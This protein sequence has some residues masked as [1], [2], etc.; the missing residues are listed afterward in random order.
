MQDAERLAAKIK[1]DALFLAEQEVKAAR[2][3]IRQEMAEQ[4]EAT[5]KELI[6]RYLTPVDQSH[7]VADFIQNIGQ[8][9]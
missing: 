4:A 1:E 9:R 6:Q 2:Q 5:A 3:K 7:L 8:V